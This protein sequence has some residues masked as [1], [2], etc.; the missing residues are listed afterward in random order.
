MGEFLAGLSD[1]QLKGIKVAVFDTRVKNFMSGDALKKIS[2]ELKRAG[3]E[4]SAKSQAFFVK[5]KEGP[6]FEGEV[7]KAIEWTKSIKTLFTD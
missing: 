5:G 2:K 1:S 4:I 3:A 6:L 7:D